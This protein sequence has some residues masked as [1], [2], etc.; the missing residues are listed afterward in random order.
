VATNPLP[1]SVPS[2]RGK[3]LGLAG[4]SSVALDRGTIRGAPNSVV[5]S[6]RNTNN[7]TCRNGGEL[8]GTRIVWLR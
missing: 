4:R 6:D 7:S 1:L 2:L 5:T 8:E 3:K